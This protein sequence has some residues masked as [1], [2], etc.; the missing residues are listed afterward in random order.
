MSNEVEKTDKEKKAEYMRDYHAKNK[1][2]TAKYMSEYQKKNKEKVNAIN[3]KSYINNN[4]NERQKKRYMEDE[5][6]RMEKIE[7]ASKWNEEHQEE[8]R[9]Y[10]RD[11]MREYRKR[12]KH[13]D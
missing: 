11:Y 1:E 12:N 10:M 6:Y 5:A 3:R 9:D 13:N 8:R 2:K 7:R 4:Q